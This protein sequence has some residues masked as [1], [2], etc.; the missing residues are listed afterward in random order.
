MQFLKGLCKCILGF[1]IGA[2]MILIILSFSVKGLFS[3]IILKSST[4]ATKIASDELAENVKTGNEVIDEKVQEL[5]KDKELIPLRIK[6]LLDKKYLFFC[7][8]RKNHWLLKKK[9]E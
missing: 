8:D 9:K 4:I 5:L 3:D 6:A 7:S 2:S 1:L